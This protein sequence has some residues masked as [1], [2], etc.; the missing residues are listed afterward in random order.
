MTDAKTA[1]V[2][3]DED[4]VSYLIS[5]LLQKNGYTVTHASDGEK[6]MSLIDSSTPP[7]VIILDVMLPYYD[8]HKLLQHLRANPQWTEVPVLM[9]TAKSREQDISLAL[10]NGAND[11]MV[12]PF[13][14]SELISRINKLVDAKKTYQS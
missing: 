11:Y 5:F 7:K 2:V 9:L 1:L 12:K 3:E 4:Y 8:G 6:A 14:P 13:Q 10:D